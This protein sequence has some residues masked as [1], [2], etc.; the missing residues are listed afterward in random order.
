VNGQLQRVGPGS[1]IFQ[2]SNQ[3]HSIRNVGS[4]PATYHVIQWQPP[5][6]KK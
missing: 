3:M 5:G 2:A 1:V 4:T 6:M